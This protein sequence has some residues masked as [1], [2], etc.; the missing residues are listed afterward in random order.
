[1]ADDAELMNAACK[2][3]LVTFRN[4]KFKPPVTKAEPRQKL[5]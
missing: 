4:L 5:R 3:P 2:K 1:M